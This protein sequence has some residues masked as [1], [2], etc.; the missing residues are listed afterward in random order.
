[1]SPLFRDRIDA[2]EQLAQAIHAILLRRRL[3]EFWLPPVVL[4]R[5]EWQHRWRPTKLPLD[6]GGEKLA[7]KNPD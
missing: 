4:P 1:M 2:G 6:C 5:E 3:M 7:I